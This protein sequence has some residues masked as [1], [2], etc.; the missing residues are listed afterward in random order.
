MRLQRGRVELG[1]QDVAQRVALERA[2]DDA[3]EPVDVLQHAV[4]VVRRG[5]AQVGLVTRAPRL[6]Q[7]STASLPSSSASSKSKRIMTCRL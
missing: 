4:P 3:A 1:A 6:G 7:V 2:A 5:D